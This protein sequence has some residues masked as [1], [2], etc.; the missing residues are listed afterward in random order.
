[1]RRRFHR[2]L[3]ALLLVALPWQA[4]AASR[5]IACAEAAPAAGP[6]AVA[7]CHDASAHDGAAAV[8]DHVAKGAVWQPCSGCA[9]CQACTASA[10]PT[11]A[12]D[13]LSVSPLHPVFTV[14]PAIAGVVLDRFDRPPVG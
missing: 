7:A 8:P 12:P 10:L 4:I 3:A 9:Q 5:M 1:M 11:T 2:L 14:S 13:T 6:A